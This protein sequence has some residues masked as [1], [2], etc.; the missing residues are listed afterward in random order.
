LNDTKQMI[1]T[2]IFI[3]VGFI[4]PMFFH[5][6]GMSGAIF[7]PM[8]IP[9]LFGGLL[10]GWRSGL[11]IGVVTP[12][13]TSLFTGMPPI[14]PQALIM[15]VE[16]GL[17]G[18]VGGY[19]YRSKKKPLFA[20]LLL[21]MLAGRLGTALVLGLFAGILGIHMSPFIYLTMSLV[22]GLPGIVIQLCFIPILMEYLNKNLPEWSGRNEKE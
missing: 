11:I 1:L 15:T 3:A 20:A 12:L 18:M 21:A 19:F 16:L 13:L 17:Y 7:L 2:A 14:F 5:M 8:H 4:L 22:E 9:V 10:L 6:L